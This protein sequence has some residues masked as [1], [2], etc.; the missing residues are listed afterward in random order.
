[1]KTGTKFPMGL[2]TK[3]EV[4]K[5]INQFR[6]LKPGDKIY[7]EQIERL[8]GVKK[9]TYRFRSII[10]AW[11]KQL[12]N[13]YNI[14]LAAVMNE[15]YQVMNGSERIEFAAKTTKYG[16]KRVRRAGDVVLRT[17][18]IDLK[19]EERIIADHL[20]KVAAAING[21]YALQRKELTYELKDVSKK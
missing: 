7:Y 11:R 10:V 3:P 9:D 17:N 6:N 12:R 1:M 5:L 8:I 19:P 21:H 18:R 16:V 20:V 2:P 14:E 4:D 13:E 15:G